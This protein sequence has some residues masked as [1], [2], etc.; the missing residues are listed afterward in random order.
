MGAGLSS[1]SNESPECIF[2]LKISASIPVEQVIAVA[3]KAGKAIL[4]IYN[5]EASKWEVELKSDQS[6][7]TKADRVANQLICHELHRM[8]P[9]IPIMSEENAIM[10]YDIRKGYEYYWCVDPLDGTKEFLKRNGEFT[11]NIALMFHGQ[12]VLGVVHVPCTGKTYWAVKDKG[13][14]KRH[15]T[16][17]GAPQERLQAASFGLRD[18]GLVVVGSSSHPS[19]A[20]EEL[21]EL[22]NQPELM[23]FGS[24]LKLLMVAEGSAHIYPRLV[25]CCEWDTAAADIIV[26]EAGGVVLQ[27]GLCDGEGN[28]I[29]E[30]WKTVLPKE[31]PLEYNKENLLNPFF[32]V[33][34]QR[35]LEA[36]DVKDPMTSAWNLLSGVTAISKA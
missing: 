22:F 14:W 25:P 28:G 10:P 8:S 11:V 23:H 21:I 9:H 35:R 34:G 26:R 29:G 24:S 4:E 33:F 17:P 32:V 12:P 2:E 13:A 20:T 18:P 6:P 36:S 27:A 5:S 1:P 15:G 7:L 3:Q 30:D 31:L 16:G 19:K